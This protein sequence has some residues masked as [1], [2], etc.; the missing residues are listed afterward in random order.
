MVH[1]QEKRKMTRIKLIAMLASMWL[2]SQAIA[3]D[4]QAVMALTDDPKIRKQLG[5]LEKEPTIRQVQDAALH[6][7]RVDPTKVQSFRSGATLKG[8][9]PITTISGSQRF[10]NSERILDDRLYNF[11]PYKEAEDFTG[12]DLVVGVSATWN[13]PL[14]MFN[15]EE[16]DVASL[17]GIMEGIL[18]E[19]TTLYFT[20]RRL[21]VDLILTPPKD[22]ASMLSKQIRLQELTS[23]IDAETG[24]FYKREVDRIKKENAAT[25]LPAN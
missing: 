19:V 7:F 20:R 6:F 1:F 15:A 2:S 24:G 10:Y 25:P 23:I 13:F 21:Q 22:M 3:Q 16:L 18:K 9:F 14:L 17:V 4:Y 5:D 8:W 11:D 12:D